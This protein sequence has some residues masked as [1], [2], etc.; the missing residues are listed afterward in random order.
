MSIQNAVFVCAD[1][2]ASPIFVKK[3]FV[4]NPENSEIEIVGLGFFE[5]RI[6]GKKVSDDLLVPPASDYGKRDLSTLYYPIR[7]TFSHRVYFCRYALADYLEHGENLI[8]IQ[9]GNGWFLQDVRTGE[10]KLS[11]GTPR[12]AFSLTADGTEYLSDETLLW[13]ESCIV[14]NNIYTGEIHDFRHEDHVLKPVSVAE[15]PSGKLMESDAPHDRVIRKIKPARIFSDGERAIYDAGVNLSGVVSFVQDGVY[16]EQTVLRFAEKLGEDLS[17]SFETT[18]PII[19][20]D[21]FISGGE[22]IRC[23]PKFVFHGFRYFEI[24]GKAE[25]VWVHEIHSDIP[26]RAKFYSDN[27]VL[28]FLYTASLRSLYSNMHSA[29]ITD[30]PHRERLG[31]TGD[32]QLTADLALTVL[33]SEKLYEKWMRDIADG[34]DPETGHVQHTAPFEGGGGGPGGWGGAIVI[35]PYMIYLHHDRVDLLREYYPHMKKYIAYMES[36]SEDGLVVREEEKGWCLGDWCTADK[37]AIPEPFVNTYFLIKCLDYMV[38]ISYILDDFDAPWARKS[39]ELRAALRR[40][41]YDAEKNTY[42]GGVQGADA[43]AMDIGIGDVPM[44][45]ALAKKYD[46]MGAF[47]TGIFGTDILIRVLFENGFGDTAMR[48]LTSEKEN[49]YGAWL[50]RGETSLCEYWDDRRSHNHHMFAAPLR[51]VFSRVLGVDDSGGM[52][53]IAPVELSA[54]ISLEAEMETKFGHVFV[55]REITEK[56][57]SMTLRASYPAFFR[58]KDTQLSLVPNEEMILQFYNFNS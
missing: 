2:K 9:L 43:F 5:L 18:G 34:Q 38:E 13:K 24:V 33:S 3:I 23:T 46:E 57:E 31:Y 7:D 12:L 55:R 45:Q 48:L 28:N 52:L 27:E 16:G 8:E 1:T 39:A 25:D 26:V 49:S 6:N 11:Y 42:C 15:A 20:S 53:I 51:Y 29:V 58:Y 36:R 41:Y 32:G 30:C 35:V 50:R 40:H 10:G 19:Q 22:R 4:K 14:E 47:D 44:V 54:P 17:L 37:I 56:G 21:T